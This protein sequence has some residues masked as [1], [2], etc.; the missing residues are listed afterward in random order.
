MHHTTRNY[1]IPISIG[2]IL[3]L[4][5]FISVVWFVDPYTS[6]LLQH[7]FFYLTLFLTS[8]GILTLGGVVLRKR[9]S[10]GMFTEQLRTSFR[11]S[12]LLS[13][14][15]IGLLLLQVNNLLLWWVGLTLVLFIITVEIFLNS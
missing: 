15:I 10:P 1:L 4:A 2:T 12:I 6:G 9:L 3:S 8:A 7:I 5:A 13:L 14:M 11:Q